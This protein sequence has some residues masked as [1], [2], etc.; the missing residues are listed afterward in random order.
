[1]SIENARLIRI[2]FGYLEHQ[3]RPIPLLFFFSF[4]SFP[5]ERNLSDR[6]IRAGVRTVDCG[7]RLVS[8]A[9]G[10]AWT[11][12]ARWS[13]AGRNPSGRSQALPNRTSVLLT[14]LRQTRAA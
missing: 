6:R 12:T 10:K 3:D 5:R 14:K 8:S 2:Q 13:H 7:K 9:P 1:M 11:A 4:S